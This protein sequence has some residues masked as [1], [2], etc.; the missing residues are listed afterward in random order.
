MP[1]T[2]DKPTRAITNLY[3]LPT[4]LPVTLPAVN[5]SSG[6]LDRFPLENEILSGK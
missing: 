4:Y 6:R 1:T 5:E 3:T 2:N